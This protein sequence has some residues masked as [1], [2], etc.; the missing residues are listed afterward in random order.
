[1]KKLIITADDY[2]YID[3][4]DEAIVNCVK[5]GAVTTVSC[6]AHV[7]E[8]NLKEKIDALLHAFEEGGKTPGIGLHFTITSGQP[9]TNSDRLS[10]NGRFYPINEIAL[11][12]LRKN[13]I[14]HELEAQYDQLQTALDG[15]A[16]V[17]HLSCHHG[18]V[19]YHRRSFNAYVSF[20]KTYQLPVRSPRMWTKFYLYKFERDGVIDLLNADIHEEGFR[21]K[22]K[23]VFRALRWMVRTSKGKLEA[24]EQQIRDAGLKTP[25]VLM[26]QIYGDP[27]LEWMEYYLKVLKS[28]IVAEQMMHV[29]VPYSLPAYKSG[30][31]GINSDYFSGRMEE[32]NLMI[33]PFYT[34]LCEEMLDG[35]ELKT[36]T[37]RELL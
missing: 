36:G 11:N 3:H 37:Y 4:I 14:Y 25:D 2:G 23:G 8:H 17:D 16:S 28:N 9:L 6:F 20:A 31:H 12:R 18:T 32:Y 27:R 33:N 7:P 13:D 34:Q 1:M 21:K 29:S 26:D 15:R 22:P 5:K 24:M 19:N 30:Y 35:E 10:E